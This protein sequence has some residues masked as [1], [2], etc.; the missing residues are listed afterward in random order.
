MPL[1]MA[2]AGERNTVKAIRGRDD[3]RR[4]LQNLGFSE[5][6]EV[7]IVSENG[8]NLI[9]SIMESRIAISKS[10]ASRILI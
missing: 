7:M 8:G 3:T 1:S 10:M 6:R 4:F 2:N 9:V 5:G